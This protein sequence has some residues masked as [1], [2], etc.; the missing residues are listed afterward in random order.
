[1]TLIPARTRVVMKDT[2]HKVGCFLGLVKKHNI[3]NIKL[4]INELIQ[5]IQISVNF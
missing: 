2:F 5:A 4:S 3:T 1:M